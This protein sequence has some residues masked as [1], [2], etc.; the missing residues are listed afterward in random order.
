[1]YIFYSCSLATNKKKKGKK[2]KQPQLVDDENYTNS[3][4]KQTQMWLN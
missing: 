3:V 1:M 2:Y 4:E